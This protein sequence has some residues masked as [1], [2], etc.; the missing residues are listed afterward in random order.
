MS[1]RILL[2]SQALYHTLNRLSYELIENYNDFENTVIISLQP[3]GGFLGTRISQL[4]KEKIGKE[5]KHGLLDITF[6]RDDFRRSERPIE[7]NKTD[8]SFLIEGKKVVLI[9]DVL[10]SGR[11]VRSGMDALLAYG[12]PSQVELLVLIDRR[13][14]RHL[15]ITPNYVGRIVDTMENERVSVEWSES[16]G[17]D[18][19]LL[20]T[21]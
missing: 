20:Y 10:Y 1:P 11:S 15:P 17:E 3:R 21:K 8:I 2:D 6:F 16:E 9:D 4:L 19:V 12:R 14:T 5:I 13:Y 7:P 18:K